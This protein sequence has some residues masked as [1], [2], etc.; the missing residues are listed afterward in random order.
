MRGQMQEHALSTTAIL[1]YGN[2]VFAH[3][4]IVTKL[5]NGEWHR[6]TYAD[7]YRRTRQLASALAHKLNVRVGDRVGTFAW[8]HYQHVELYYGIPAMGAICHPINIRLSSDQIA[9]IANHAEDEV[10][11]IDATLVPLFEKIID[12]TPNVKH[13]IL[14]NA[15]ADFQCKLPNTMHYEDLLADAPED[16]EFHAIDE[17]DACGLSYTSGTTGDPKGALYSHRSTYLHAMGLMMPNATDISARERVLLIV[18]QFHVMAW[19][20][21]YLCMM[22]GADMILP[23]MYLQPDALIDIIQRER[24]TIA[25]GVPTIWQGVYDALKR[26]PPAEKLTLREY[27]VGGSAL[28]PTL[29]EGFQRDFGISGLHA[30]GMTETSPI[31]TVSRLQPV[32]ASLSDAEK[33]KIRATQGIEIPGVELRLVDDDGNIVARDGKSVGELQIRGQWVI[34]S[35]FKYAAQHNCF[36]KDGWFKTGDVAT[37][38][39]HGYMTITD[40]TK[41]LIKSGGEWISSVALEVALMAHPQIKEAC[42]IAIP[43]PK[44]TERPLACVVFRDG[45]A[46]SKDELRAFLAPHFASYQIPDLFAAIK[47]VPK[48][49]VGKFDKKEL[50]RMYAEGLI[51]L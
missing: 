41:D 47:E 48:T 36:T 50:R 10:I 33:I 23:S 25:N 30:W 4:E 2:R 3:K 40:R 34:E 24:V 38:D 14:L 39:K 26:N 31:G 21:P 12:R 15:P 19:G 46:V 29:I 51:Q 13:F 32:H 9:F 28:P 49:S 18:P 35:Y 6:Y 42:V 20:F 11:F 27:I 7:M 1:E 8:N 44:W 45:Q 22:A 43:D 5:P 37:I 17:N 16:F